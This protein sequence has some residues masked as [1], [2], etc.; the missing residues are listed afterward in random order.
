MLKRHVTH[1]IGCLKVNQN[2]MLSCQSAAYE[3]VC[4][5]VHGREAEPQIAFN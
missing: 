4:E 5:C 2:D 1:P 3:C